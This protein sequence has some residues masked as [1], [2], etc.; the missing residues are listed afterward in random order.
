MEQPKTFDDIECIGA[1]VIEE[2]NV[3][4]LRLIALDME[5]LAETLGDDDQVLSIDCSWQGDGWFIENM[6]TIRGCY[7]EHKEESL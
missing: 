7:S 6:Q 4:Y 1:T 2:G 5:Y 3:H